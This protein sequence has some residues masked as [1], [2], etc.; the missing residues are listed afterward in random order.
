MGVPV[1]IRLVMRMREVNRRRFL[2]LANYG[3]NSLLYF[4]NYQNAG[5]GS[6]LYLNARTGTGVNSSGGFFDILAA[7]VAGDQLPSVSWIVAPE[8]YTEHPAWPAGYGAW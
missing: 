5:P 3:D 2:Q 1:D 8:A 4:L 6:P 7:D